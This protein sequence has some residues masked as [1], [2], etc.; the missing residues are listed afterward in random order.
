MILE[1]TPKI[2]SLWDPDVTL[3][4]GVDKEKVSV[5]HAKAKGLRYLQNF[6]VFSIREDTPCHVAWCDPAMQTDYKTYVI[7][8]SRVPEHFRLQA[9][10]ERLLFAE[11]VVKCDG[12]IEWI[13]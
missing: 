10:W 8:Y 4:V 12:N 9:I 5:A 13:S 11:D 2:A 6:D 7:Y 1:P 3:I